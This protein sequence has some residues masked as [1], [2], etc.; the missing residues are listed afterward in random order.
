MDTTT[1][2]GQ[3]DVDGIATVTVTLDTVQ[4][5]DLFDLDAE[6]RSY[7]DTKAWSAREG[8]GDT[9]TFREHL[10]SRIREDVIVEGARAWNG[11]GCSFQVDTTTL[12]IDGYQ[13]R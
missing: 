3:M 9:G 12:R 7:L 13:E 4:L 8:Y 2:G 1:T 5:R 11:S 6:Y 10:E